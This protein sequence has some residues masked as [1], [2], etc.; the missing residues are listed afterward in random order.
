MEV[1]EIVNVSVNTPYPGTQTWLTES[2]Q[3]TT[4]DYRLFDVQHAVLPTK[5][6]LPE[7]YA[8][9]VKTQQVL[10]KKHMGGAA[11]KSFGKV[12][13]IATKLLLKGQTNFINMLWNFGKVYNPELLL[14]D[15]QQAVKYEMSLPPSPQQKVDV[16]TTYIHAPGGR[17]G[18]AFEKDLSKLR[19]KAL[20]TR[21]K[22][23]ILEIEDAETLEDVSNVKKLKTEGNYY[24]IRVGDYRIGLLF[25]EDVVVFVR[26]LHRKEVYRYFP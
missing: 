14:S 17:R 21:I 25:N 18:R 15:H 26:V 9:L 12:A 2:R 6:P 5:L 23:V 1:P 16:K 24:R 11:F 4:R 20:L 13:K 7:F 3:L 22:A 19:D 8:E 10:H